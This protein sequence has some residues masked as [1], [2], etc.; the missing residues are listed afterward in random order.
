[1]K[2]WFLKLVAAIQSAQQRRA[3]EALRRYGYSAQ[4]DAYIR[5][6]GVTDTV[7]LEY[8]VKEFE[9]MKGTRYA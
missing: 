2:S 7:Q 8:W 4:L 9:R 6:K 1:M 5:E 3:Y